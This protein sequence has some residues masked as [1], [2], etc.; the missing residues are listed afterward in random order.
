[1]E[2]IPDEAIEVPDYDIDDQTRI[3]KNVLPFDEGEYE[4]EKEQEVPDYS[5]PAEGLEEDILPEERLFPEEDILPEKAILPDSED[6]TLP[7]EKQLTRPC[8]APLPLV[9]STSASPPPPYSP[10]PSPYSPPPGYLKW[11][12]KDPESV[13]LATLEKFL[14][15]NK[16]ILD[17]VF[18]TP[19]S[20]FYG[21]DKTRVENK[22]FSIF[23]KRA[24]KILMNQPIGQKRLGDF[25]GKSRKQIRDMLGIEGKTPEEI[26][27]MTLFADDLKEDIIKMTRSRLTSLIDRL[28]LGISSLHAGNT[29]VKL[30]KEIQSIADRLL[31]AKVI[32]KEQ[33]KQN[34]FFK[35]SLSILLDSQLAKQ[36]NGKKNRNLMISRFSLMNQSFW[37]KTRITKLL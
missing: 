16:G 6:E 15:N 21:W 32:S 25:T 19:K 20:K 1:M 29:S 35:M 24:K 18:S 13:D 12:K 11:R 14:R 31:E 28:N 7:G 9:A 22:I 17:A 30:K 34:S 27:Q 3:F 2:K 36:Q 5:L 4:Y 37:I 33:K 26:Q 23:A 8:S 10:P